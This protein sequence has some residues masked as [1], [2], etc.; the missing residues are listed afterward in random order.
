[1]SRILGYIVLGIVA[2][3]VIATVISIAFSIFGFVWGLF[4]ILFKLAV[5]GAIV[6]FGWQV[7]ERVRQRA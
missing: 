2:L 7:V 3:L 1:M 5:F 6:W 4:K